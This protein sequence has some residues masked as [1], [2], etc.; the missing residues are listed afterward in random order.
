MAKATKSLAHKVPASATAL[1]FTR[2]DPKGRGRPVFWAVHST[3]DW[4]ADCAT[5]EEY[6][7][8]YLERTRCR[9]IPPL[10]WIVRD[11]VAA[12]GEKFGGVE[13]GFL[14]HLSRSHAMALRAW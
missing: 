7:R 10:S 8:L 9:G 4:G 14:Q 5:G 6:A 3:G 1:P 12:G 11:M 13:T 2:E